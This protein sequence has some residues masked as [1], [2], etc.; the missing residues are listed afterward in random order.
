[1]TVLAQEVIDDFDG[2]KQLF[3]ADT[4]SINGKI[5]QRRFDGKYAVN[6]DCTGAAVLAFSDS[7]QVNIEFQIVEDGEEVRFIQ[8]DAG[9]VVTGEAK[10]ISALFPLLQE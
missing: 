3:G 1:M 10:Q 4:A 9:T 7:E 5:S 8:T 2:Q 6:G